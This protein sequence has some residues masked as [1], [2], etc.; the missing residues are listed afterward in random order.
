M[1]KVLTTLL[2]VGLLV[3]TLVACSSTCKESGCDEKAYK[4][5]YC[6]LHYALHQA[7]N[8]LGGLFG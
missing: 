3:L 1:K 4:D 5:G 8:L 7:E 6:E 2:L